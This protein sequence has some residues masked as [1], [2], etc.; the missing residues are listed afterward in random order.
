MKI[1]EKFIKSGNELCDFDNHVPAPY[2]RKTFELEFC[3]KKAEIT[4]CGLGFYELYINGKDITKGPLA[5]Y[6]SNPDD[7][8]YYDNYDITKLLSKGKNAIGI[9]LGNGMRNA[10]GGFVWD[11]D[12]AASRGNVCTSLCLEASDEKNTFELEADESF[13]THP[14]PIIFDDLRM[15]CRY[16][17]RLEI[18]GW[19]SADFD[20]SKWKNAIFEKTPRGERVLCEAEPIKI[21]GEVYAKEIKHFDSAP[22]AFE[23]REVDAKPVLSTVRENVYVY[24][25]GINSAGVSKIFIKNA[26]PGQVITV[27]HAEAKHKD[28]VSVNTTVFHGGK[29]FETYLEYG[30]TDIYICKGGDETFVPKFKYD[31]FQ[32][33]Y[34][35]GLTKEQATKDAVVML[36]MSSDLKERAS[37]ESS[38][39]TLN[40]LWEITRRSD[41]SNFFYFPTDCPHREKNGWTGDAAMSSEQLLLNLTCENSFKVW[42][43]NIKKAQRI[44]GAIPGIVPTGGWGFAW[45]NG[46]AWDLICVNPAYY[47]YRFTGDKTVIYDCAPMIMRY[48]YYVMTRRDDKGLIHIGLGDWLDPYRTNDTDYSSPLEFTDSAMVFDIARKAAFLFSEAGLNFESE[49]AKSVADCMR[50]NIREHLIDK[51]TAAVAG[52]CQTSQAVAL[53]LGLFD[54]DEIDGAREKL[55]SLAMEADCTHTCGMIGLR[56]IFHALTSAGRTDLAYKMITSKSRTGFGYWVENGATSLWEEFADLDVRLGSSRNHHF[57]GDISS[58]FVQCLV[59][60]RPNPNCINTSEFEFLP[61]LIDE[62]KR[63]GCTYKS[64]LGDVCA[65][66]EISDG[67][68]AVLEV[69]CP[70]K[71]FG[72]IKLPSGWCFVDGETEKEFKTGTYI[73]RK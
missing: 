44:D 72:K 28:T 55:I 7:Y 68:E 47:I 40:K 65:S 58:W 54:N 46:P 18:N 20:D 43:K 34:I 9:I 5:P 64:E 49:Y 39:E 53:E 73:C 21:R 23:S 57:Y 29:K 41:L 70:K 8:C 38:D 50:E 48:L 19:A 71:I 59:G 33:V 37:F 11:F 26:K 3:P 60:L 27:R 2:L 4:I 32:Y 63:A 30:Q 16:D 67:K 6:I 52:N 69:T 56:Y 17:A 10:F 35:E 25:F 15:G 62:V 31:G 1:S 24:D 61:S 66:Y 22:F 13:K 45:G 36:E 12:K 51:K 42:L 14:S